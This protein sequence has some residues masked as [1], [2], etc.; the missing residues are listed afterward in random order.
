MI[1]R[2]CAFNDASCRLTTS[3]FSE[4]DLPTGKP[5]VLFAETETIRS[6]RNTNGS[7]KLGEVIYQNDQAITDA[8]RAADA[9]QLD[10]YRS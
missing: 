7:V 3:V 4:V 6:I 8:E 1:R 10:L 2:H 9:T 5:A